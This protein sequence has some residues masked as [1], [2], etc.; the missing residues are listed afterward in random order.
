[1]GCAELGVL[2]ILRGNPSFL[3]LGMTSLRL[4]GW[5]KTGKKA[6]GRHFEGL[7]A[8]SVFEFAAYDDRNNL[9]GRCVGYISAKGEQGRIDGGIVYLGGIICVQ[10]GYY[11]YWVEST[12]GPYAVDRQVTFHFCEVPMSRCKSATMYRDSL[13]VDVFRLLSFDQLQK[14]SWLSAT[15]LDRLNDHPAVIGLQDPQVGGGSPGLSADLGTL[16]PGGVALEAKQAEVQEGRLGIEGLAKALGAD[17]AQKLAEGG[18]LE[19]SDEPEKEKRRRTRDKEKKKKRKAA[20]SDEHES[21]DLREEL[22]RKKPREPRLSALDLSNLTKKKKKKS[23]ESKDR[24]DKKRDYSPS[25]SSVTDE[26]FRSAA[27]PKGME[28]L[29]R[30]HQKSPGRIASVSLQR[31]QE[32]VEQTTGRGTA[33]VEEKSLLPAVAQAY[34]TQVFVTR[35]SGHDIPLRTMREMKTLAAC[36]DLVAMNDPLRALDIMIQRFKSLE[37]AHLQGNWTQACQ[38]ELILPDMSGAVFRQ[39]VK[40]AQAEVKTNWD[41]ERGPLRGKGERWRWRD[42]HIPDDVKD[43]KEGDEKGDQPPRNQPVKRKGKGK[44]KKGKYRRW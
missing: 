33:V 21:D 24:D 40:A 41:L 38:L 34:L 13:H 36:I 30:V 26:L 39:E 20:P 42:D 14:L 12:Y 15:D 1:M 28:N 37:L 9:Q 7:E 6:D 17:E 25:S 44:G 5:R 29:R 27:L 22:N 31:L 18:E 8:G 3:N 2:L 4:P 43:N 11:E 19:S 32:V 16:K 10:D 35:N 23:K